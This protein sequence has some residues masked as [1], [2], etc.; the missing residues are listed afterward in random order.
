MQLRDINSD[1]RFSGIYKWENTVNGKVYIGQSQDIF[2]RFK[3]Y[4]KGK[5]NVHMANAIEKYGMDAFNI[6]IVEKDVHLEKLDEREQFWMD[7]YQSYNRDF[8]YNILPSAGSFRGFRHSEE[9]KL[10][11]S[12]NALGRTGLMLGRHHTP[13]T[14]RKMSESHTNIPTGRPITEEQQRK[15]QEGAKKTVWKPVAKLDLETGETVATYP[16]LREAARQHNVN[17]CGIQRCC[18][19][20]Q[21]EY[22]GFAWAYIARNEVA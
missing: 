22:L 13:E 8:G 3:D 2:T 1:F 9:T 16:S 6:E 5:F 7:F 12:L 19:G 11:M 17:K 15:M 10:R 21:S 20:L 18:V 4:K 14:R